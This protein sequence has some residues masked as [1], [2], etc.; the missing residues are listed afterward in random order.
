MS[1]AAF[2]ACS[3]GKLERAAPRS[4]RGRTGR[5]RA[6]PAASS[7]NAEA[8]VDALPVVLLRRGLP[9]ADDA[10]VL[11]LDEHRVH[12]LVGRAG[13][14]ERLAQRERHRPV[15]QLHGGYTKPPAPVAQGIER[16]PPER[17]V[18]GSIPARRIA[19]RRPAVEPAGSERETIGSTP[20]NREGKADEAELAGRARVRGS[21]IACGRHGVGR[22]HPG[23]LGERSERLRRPRRHIRQPFRRRATPPHFVNYVAHIAN[24]GNQSATHTGADLELSGGWC[25]TRRPRASVPARSTAHPTCTLGRLAGG[26][27][28]TVEF[29]ARVPETEGTGRATLTVNLRRSATTARR[30]TRSRTR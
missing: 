26:A 21:G 24:D 22:E 27:D 20:G 30:T 6:G 3:P 7:R 19:V 14:R 2:A 13:D 9:V 23:V 5:R 15:G 1:T 16:A 8:D 25:W 18:A 29:V 28:A 17:K 12:G 4:R 11:D 10:V